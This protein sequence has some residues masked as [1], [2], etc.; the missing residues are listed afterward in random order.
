MRF[1]VAA[2]LIFA[3]SA[4]TLTE[5]Q[6]QRHFSAFQQ[7]FAKNYTD[8]ESELRYGIFKDNLDTINT[9]NAKNK[10]WTMGVN[11]FAD[12]TPLEFTA[13]VKRGSG[14]GYVHLK[15]REKRYGEPQ[16]PNCDSSDLVTAG[17]VTAVK[18]QGNC[19]SCWSFSTTGAIEG[20]LGQNP[21]PL[22]EQMLV[23]CDSQDSA[24]NGGLMDY[25]FQYVEA[26]GLCSESDYAYT[27]KK[28]WFCHSSSCS[29]VAGSKIT[30]YTDIQEGD[31]DSMAARLCTHPVSVAIEADQTSFQFYSG[32]VLTD[33]CGDS[34][35]HGVLVVGFGKDGSDAY[36][37][38]KNSWGDSWGEQG[39]IRICKDCGANNGKGQC[40][41]LSAASYP[42][43]D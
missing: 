38:V 5:F 8:A 21:T 33:A 31:G 41:V 28:S 24:C 23:D 42:T 25:A 4:R 9:H 2:L 1:F 19:G 20:L 26:H 39:Y 27:A 14:G 37:K 10:S 34:L 30:G 40:G 12:M 15:N 7:K 35:D 17:V 16:T 29:V 22:S 11:Q 18:N 36:W 43:N 32:G 3:I 6:Y 13:W